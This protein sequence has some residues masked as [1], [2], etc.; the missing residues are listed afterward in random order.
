MARL[1]S[2]LHP[3]PLIQLHIIIHIASMLKWLHND[4]NKGR[5]YFMLE[6]EMLFYLSKPM[7]YRYCGRRIG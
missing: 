2:N 6:M 1:S 3:M 7:H 5:I 4:P